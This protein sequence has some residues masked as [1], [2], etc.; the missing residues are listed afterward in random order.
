MTKVIY[1]YRVFFDHEE[2]VLLWVTTNGSDRFKALD[3]GSLFVA[4][5]RSDVEQ[6]LGKEAALVRWD[7]EASLDMDEFWTKVN[8]LRV[9]RSSSVLTCK[10]ILE[11]WNFFDDVLG[12]LSKPEL[13]KSSKSPALKKIYDKLFFGNNLK[14]VTPPGQSYN[15]RW[16]AEEISSF[17]RAM[18]SI[19]KG[20]QKD[21]TIESA[22]G[23][24]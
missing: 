24:M 14:A 22:H 23:A 20:V 7:E 11:G 12:T 2:R 1:P 13:L 10:V 4:R 16:T 3:D 9:A 18:Q 15:P 6:R 8:G 17:K 5:S 21:L 19:W